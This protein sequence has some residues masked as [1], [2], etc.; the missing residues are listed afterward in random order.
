M[1]CNR[2]A[3][4]WNDTH[5]GMLQ[6]GDVA[7]CFKDALSSGGLKLCGISET[8][9]AVLRVCWN[10]E[11]SPAVLRI[12]CGGMMVFGDVAGCCITLGVF[13]CCT[14][15]LTSDS[16]LYSQLLKKSN[17]ESQ[18]VSEHKH[19]QSRSHNRARRFQ[20]CNSLNEVT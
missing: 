6:F 18:I 16:K 20:R 10:S 19:S 8:S 2:R 14:T 9:P 11:T 12:R 5:D 4:T 7:G 1:V 13:R 15:P 17:Y 3:R